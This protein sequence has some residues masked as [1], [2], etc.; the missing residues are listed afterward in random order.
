MA[1]LRLIFAFSSPAIT[2]KEGVL[3]GLVVS[4]PLGLVAVAACML[5]QRRLLRVFIL[6]FYLSVS[7][8]YA[9]VVANDARLRLY[10]ARWA[11][12]A[13]ILA[14]VT[15]PVTVTGLYFVLRVCEKALRRRRPVAR[16]FP[17]G[18]VKSGRD[19]F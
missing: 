18:K 8:W 6:F 3:E 11:D 2:V 17:V 1:V 10:G 4:V 16:G 13:R 15:A 5:I 19:E 14:A 9:S 12:I 7:L